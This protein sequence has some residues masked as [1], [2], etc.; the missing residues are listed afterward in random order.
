M[1]DSSADALE[2]ESS[3]VIEVDIQALCRICGNINE[4]LVPIFEDQGKENDLGPKINQHLPIQ[5]NLFISQIQK[6]ILILKSF[7][8][9]NQSDSLP[10][11]ICINCITTLLNFNSLANCCT[12]TNKRFQEIVQSTGVEIESKYIDN[13]L[14]TGDRAK[15]DTDDEMDGEVV[16]DNDCDS[17]VPMHLEEKGDE[18]GNDYD[19]E[20]LEN[21]VI[22]LFYLFCFK[23]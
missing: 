9:V 18:E 7:S 19:V 4:F 21:E 22:F 14:I 12:E 6:K 16:D 10:L 5:V 8:K 20:Y 1:M 23:N 2:S 13:N 15:E 11:K 17:D 3:Y